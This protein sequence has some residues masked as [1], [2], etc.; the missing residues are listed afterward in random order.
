MAGAGDAQGR[1][2][3]DIDRLGREPRLLFCVGQLGLACGD[4]L[5]NACACLAHELAQGSLLIGRHIAQQ[6]VEACERRRLA[7]VGRLGGLERSSVAGCGYGRERSLDGG[8]DGRIGD[9][10]RVRHRDK[11]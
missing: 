7:S 3:R 11:A 10:E 1:D 5:R 8:I 4:G 6:R 9:R 2:A